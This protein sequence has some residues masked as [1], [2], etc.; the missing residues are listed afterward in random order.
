MYFDGQLL[1]DKPQPEQTTV[2]KVSLT[3]REGVSEIVIE[4]TP[5][6]ENCMAQCVMHDARAA[7]SPQKPVDGDTLVIPIAK[8]KTA[9][10]DAAAFKCLALAPKTP[11]ISPGGKTAIVAAIQDRFHW[12]SA[13]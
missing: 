1:I 11:F 5:R 13:S 7:N 8:G 4:L 10:P 12:A 3:L 9:N 6:G 2:F